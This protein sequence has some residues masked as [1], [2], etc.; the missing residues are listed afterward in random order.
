MDEGGF[1]TLV[2]RSKEMLISGGF[3]IYPHEIEAVLTSH[4]E[5]MEA[6]VIGVPDPEW[7][8]AAIAYVVAS[9]NAALSEEKLVGF[10]KPLLGFKT[11]KRWTITDRLPKNPNGKIDKQSLRGVIEA[12]PAGGNHV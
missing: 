3:N 8:E 2:G 7:G 1:I 10:C 9:P 11:P 5:V 4:P 12:S 6:A